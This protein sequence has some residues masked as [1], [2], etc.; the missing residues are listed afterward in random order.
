ML[1]IAPTVRREATGFFCLE[2][3]VSPEARYHGLAR[4]LLESD[5]AY[6]CAAAH[7]ETLPGCQLVH[8]LGLESLAA[9]CVV[10]RITCQNHGSFSFWLQAVE[11]RLLDLDCTHARFYQQYPD[12]M[13]EQSFTQHGYRPVVEIALLN[14]FDTTI[15]AENETK[16]IQ[17][18]PVR[19]E[20]DWSLKLSLHRD[21][22]QDPD[23]HS[24]TAD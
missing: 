15:E 21:T 10:Q 14:T 22:P 1:S 9:G 23:G 2:E 8:M 13:L 24:S 16:E 7:C 4:E 17:L 6:F 5:A 11:A 12:N 3:G 20:R 19:S 18:R